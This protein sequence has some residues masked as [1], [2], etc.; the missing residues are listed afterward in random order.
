MNMPRATRVL[1]AILILAAATGCTPPP[2][3]DSPDRP[4]RVVVLG[5]LNSSYGS[6][7]YDPEVGRAIELVV[8]QWRPEL[9]LIPGDMIA[10]QRP[11]LSDANVRAMWAAFDSVVAAPLR[12]AGIPLAFTVGNHDASGHPAHE[13]DRR[14]AA[15]HW[16]DAAH[17]PGTRR[18]DGGRYPFYYGLT[19]GGV[20]FLALDASTGGMAADTAQLAWLRR[21]LAG[22]QARDARMRIV[23]GHVPL[24]AVAEGR[25][26][27]GEVQAEPDSLRAILERGG[28]RMFVSGHH[29]AYYPGRRGGLE[30]LH[31]GALGQGPRPLIGHGAAPYKSVTVLDLFPARDSVV[32]RTYRIRGDSVELVD[33]RTL[34]SRIDGVNGHVWRRDVVADGTG[35]RP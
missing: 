6:T 10:G 31:A 33:V 19:R 14:L 3:A 32:D 11:T 24:Y 23:L 34:P 18:L 20:L 29:H 35:K 12:R 9:V 4:V 15:E 28:V 16:R 1:V 13:R 8:E 25:N 30:L 26:R 5:D 22:P 21:T 2:P 17:D 7:D 27:A